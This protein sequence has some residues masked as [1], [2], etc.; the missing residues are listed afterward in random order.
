MRHLVI[1]SLVVSII[2]GCE[3]IQNKKVIENNSTNE[4]ENNHV[5][6]HDIIVGDCFEFKD[7]T[8]SKYG[9]VLCKNLKSGKYHQFSFFPVL[10][11]ETKNGISKFSNG[12]FFYTKRQDFANPENPIEGVNVF[13][14][15][16]DRELDTVYDKLNKIGNLK[17]KKKYLSITGGT[18]AFSNKEFRNAL[19]NWTFSFGKDFSMRQLNEI[20]E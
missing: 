14:F 16:S 6:I 1:I 18:V 12:H 8:L 19:Q 13:E 10:L 3:N 4:I 11:N 5:N 2:C 9:L 20:I 7:S 17:L 15:M